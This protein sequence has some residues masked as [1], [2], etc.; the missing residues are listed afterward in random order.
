M[1]KNTVASSSAASERRIALLLIGALFLLLLLPLFSHHDC[2]GEDC[3]VCAL[4]FLTER[5]L[6]GLW[7]L[8]FS[9]FAVRHRRL[10]S[11]SFAWLR[12]CRTP[13][14]RHDKLTD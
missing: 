11:R 14:S 13:V 8:F 4:L 1:N 12:L 3:E 7:F 6:L 10:F 2:M 9:A 5:S